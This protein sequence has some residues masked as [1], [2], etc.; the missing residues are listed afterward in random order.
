[1][2][3]LFVLTTLSLLIVVSGLSQTP[4]NQDSTVLTQQ[5]QYVEC[6]R[7]DGEGKVY[8]SY[9]K[10]HDLTKQT[11][12]HCDA[13]DLTKQ[14]CPHCN[15]RDLT[16][17]TCP[18][19][20]GSDLTLDHCRHCGGDG[21]ITNY[22]NESVKCYYCFGSGKRSACVYCYGSGQRSQCYYCYGSGHKSACVYCNGRGTKSACVFCWGQSVGQCTS[23]QGNGQVLASVVE[24]A[25]IKL[26]A[27]YVAENGSYY[28]QLNDNGVPKTV[29]IRGYYRKDGTYVRSHYRSPPYS[30]PSY[31]YDQSTGRTGPGVTENGS[32][33]GE[34]SKLTGRPKT[35]YVKG[36]YRK[37]GT[38]VRGHYRSKRR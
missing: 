14:T 33:Y 7:C 23:C 37:D 30:N 27:P 12:P 25:T 32:Y 19:C 34:P 31:H 15:G 26:S 18:H 3:N 38:Y 35:V 29:Y 22:R 4:V 1:M 9:C 24:R 16:K 17:E 28:G 6:P 11:C 8:C 10:G 21:T 5:H 2:R 13:Q 36:Y 20:Y